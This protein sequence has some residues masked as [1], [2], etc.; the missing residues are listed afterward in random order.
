MQCAPYAVELRER[1]ERLPRNTPWQQ[2]WREEYERK[3][4]PERW[5]CFGEGHAQI[6]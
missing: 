6:K 4:R 5:E 2:R 1:L 3:A